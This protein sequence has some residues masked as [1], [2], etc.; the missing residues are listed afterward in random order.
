[1]KFADGKFSVADLQLEAPLVPYGKD[2]L[3]ECVKNLGHADLVKLAQAFGL[4]THGLLSTHSLMLMI[5]HHA[6]KLWYTEMGAVPESVARNYSAQLEKYQKLVEDL[7][8]GKE[9]TMASEKKAKSKKEKKTKAPKAEKLP[10]VYKVLSSK[11]DAKLSKKLENKEAKVHDTIIL[12]VLS[13]LNGDAT[14]A[15]V[16]A[17]VDKTK[18]WESNHPTDV[19]V[20]W[21]LNKLI[22]KGLV[23]SK[24]VTREA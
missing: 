24:E 5:A 8:S 16:A 2:K 14:L 17:A 11:L 20:K 6:Q 21:H 22:E 9:T 15:A 19:G 4:P 10:L 1:M 18:R 7:T 12:Q 13:E 23:A 3:Y